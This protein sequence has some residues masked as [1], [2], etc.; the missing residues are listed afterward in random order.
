MVRLTHRCRLIDYHVLSSFLTAVLWFITFIRIG[1]CILRIGFLSLSRIRSWWCCFLGAGRFS[2]CHCSCIHRI[3]GN[4]ISRRS[5]I[6]IISIFI[7]KVMRFL[8]ISFDVHHF[9][10]ILSISYTSASS[11]VIDSIFCYS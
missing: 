6:Q 3:I 8:T 1:S 11:F 4:I 5:A 10:T 7:I 9:M 2:P